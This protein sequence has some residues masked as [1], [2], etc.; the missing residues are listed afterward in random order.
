MRRLLALAALS[1][2]MA[3]AISARANRVL[4]DRVAVRFSAPE[5]G[6]VR[7]PRFIYERMLAFEA[8]L[9]ALS[10]PDRR[11]TRV[12][13]YRERHVRAAM[14]RHIA[15]TLL[16]SLHIE[17]EPSPAELVKTMEAARSMLEQRTGSREAVADAQRA[18]GI[19]QRELSALL[20]RQ[21]RA[22]L[23]LD[24]MIAP[25]LAPSDAE[26]RSVHRGGQTPFS[27]LPFEQVAGALRRW[28]VARRLGE[29]LEAFFQTARS[30]VNVVVLEPDR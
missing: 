11:G 14:E 17:P 12:S 29:A 23:Y 18:E 16:A 22:S 5:T 27:A 3:G 21:A 13:S 8:R 19:E 20:R 1:F 28:Y 4:V 26:L 24:R 2:A 25:M 30:R 9:E 7:S 6:G 10:D 15:E